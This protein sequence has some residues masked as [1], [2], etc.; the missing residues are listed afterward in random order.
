VRVEVG[1]YAWLPKSELSAEQVVNLERLLTVYPTKAS[2][3]PGD[4]PEPIYLYEHNGAYLGVPREF[5]YKHKK[6]VHNVDLRVTEG[7]DDWSPADFV[8]TLRSEQQSAVDSMISQFGAGRLGGIFQAKPGYGKTVVALATAVRLNMPTLVVVHK[9]FLMDQWIERIRTFVPGA[10]VGKVQQS[11]CDF[12]GKTFVLGMVHSLSGNSS[13]P[14]ELWQWPGCVIFDEVHRVAARTWCPV[15]AKFLAKYRLGISATLR[16]KDGADAVFWENIGPVIFEA[17]EER[18]VPVIKRVWSTFSLSKTDRFN[19]HLA[20]QSLLLRFLCASRERNDLI[21]GQ[22]VAAVRAG[23]KCLVLSGRLNHLEALEVLIRKLWP[24]ATG[25][26]SVGWYVGGRSKG[27]LIEAAK[28]KVIFGTIQYCSEG[29]DIPSLD[30][31]FLTTPMSDVE[32][33]VGRILRPSDGK[34]NPIVVDIRDDMVP[35]FEAMGKKR[36]RFYQRFV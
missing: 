23:R 3:I 7:S 21:A 2:D 4:P 27:Q 28:A 6:A 30:T 14:D 19:P 9:E 34:K 24:A 15:P 25:G 16:R 13:Y 32:Q 11:E 35:M 8:G 18:L 20:P 36:E 29:L 31:L 12:R 22:V 1:G 26:E 5:F 10:K 33:A 17:H